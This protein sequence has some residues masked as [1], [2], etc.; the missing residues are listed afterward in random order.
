MG[1][2]ESSSMDT[3]DK[4][5]PEEECTPVRNYKW[6]KT[7]SGDSTEGSSETTKEET[8][9]PSGSRVSFA[10]S[11]SDRR[12]RRGRGHHHY[13]RRQRGEEEYEEDAD[14]EEEG[15]QHR[16]HHN[17]SNKRSHGSVL[18]GVDQFQEEHCDDD[19]DDDETD[20][21]VLASMPHKSSY[22]SRTIPFRSASFS[23]VDV[24]CDGKYVRSPY[25]PI[26]LKPTAFCLNPPGSASLPARGT[27]TNN[28][29][30][31]GTIAKSKTVGLDFVPTGDENRAKVSKEYD[32][33]AK[34][35]NNNTDTKQPLTKSLSCPAGQKEATVFSGAL[36]F[37]GLKE[38]EIRVSDFEDPTS[39][40]HGDTITTNANNREVSSCS[41]SPSATP[42][43]ANAK[44]MM[45][46]FKSFS[47][48]EAET[49]DRNLSETSTTPSVFI[50]SSSV[51]VVGAAGTDD[52]V[53]TEDTV[54]NKLSNMFLLELSRGGGTDTGG[55][56]VSCSGAEDE[57]AGPDPGSSMGSNCGAPLAAR[58]GDSKP[59]FRQGSGQ[60]D[61]SDEMLPLPPPAMHRDIKHHRQALDSLIPQIPADTTSKSTPLTAALALDSST[62]CVSNAGGVPAGNSIVSAGKAP[63]RSLITGSAPTSMVTSN[64][65][66]KCGKEIAR[67]NSMSCPVSTLSSASS[68]S[69]T[70]SGLTGPVS[71][72]LSG[73]TLGARQLPPPRR[74][75]KRPLRGPYGEMLEAEMNKLITNRRRDGSSGD[76]AFE[77]L[78]ETKSS[79][80]S[81]G[82]G[83]SGSPSG[84]NPSTAGVSCAPSSSSGVASSLFSPVVGSVSTSSPKMSNPLLMASMD[85]L[86]LGKSGSS[87]SSSAGLILGPPK[88][89]ANARSRK[90]STNIPVIPNQHYTQAG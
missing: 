59:L 72:V 90:I 73:A 49:E 44:L 37:L 65:S 89:N 2:V 69:K 48:S 75:Y 9:P 87:V 54:Q 51:G 43:P 82:T 63:N 81:R 5:R 64:P 55:S 12:S 11:G 24:T 26:T 53:S 3:G 18:S 23:Q 74:Y 60:S 4:G 79:S 29:S 20:E 10:T 70:S 28:N 31:G 40:E 57:P 77:F 36:R 56:S 15:G 1:D 86:N 61:C 8:S 67:A 58:S 41:P 62:K 78:R 16:H 17:S 19:E 38:C 30:S 46:A 76:D 83:V 52:V 42:T 39:K 80:P 45:K 27:S 50:D 21:K 34:Q 88:H 84:P 22:G 13:L 85:D 47:S 7:P 14:V 6:E 32:H 35:E 66:V 33:E 68:G 25:S 71:S